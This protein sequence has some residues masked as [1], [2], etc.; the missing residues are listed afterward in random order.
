[1]LTVT[2]QGSGILFD[3]DGVLVDSTRSGERAWKT[4]SMERGLN[5][6]DVLDG[7][8]GRRSADTVALFA[9][10][11]DR[12]SALERIDEIEIADALRETRQLPGALTA[13]QSAGHN[14]AI[15][16]SASRKLLETRLTSARL[17]KPTVVVTGDDV[18]RGKPFPDAYLLASERLGVPIEE[19]I[20]VEDSLAG[21]AAGFASNAAHVLGV[22]TDALASDAS[23]VVRDLAGCLW[24]S[25]TGMTIP[26]AQ[27]LRSK[28]PHAGFG[29]Q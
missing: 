23:Y 12:Q 29:S 13:L 2:L 20:V 14:C 1:M 24:S 3:C 16:T 18:E 7:I 15:V 22:G 21:V 26:G 11:S 17:P 19:C 25:A 4:W 9:P 8:H 10:P 27:L 5:P 6:R 28:Q